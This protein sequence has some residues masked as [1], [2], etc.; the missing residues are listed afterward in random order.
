MVLKTVLGPNWIILKKKSLGFI[1]MIDIYQLETANTLP[2]SLFNLEKKD[3]DIHWFIL[4][5]M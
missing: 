5:E 2:I 4:I 1:K 3:V